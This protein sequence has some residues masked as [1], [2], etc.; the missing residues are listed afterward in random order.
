[1]STRYVKIGLSGGDKVNMKT[2]IR[3]SVMED[4]SPIIDTRLDNQD[5]KIENIVSGSPKGVYA[6]LSALQTAYPSGASGVYLTSDNGHWYY[7]N[8]SAWTDGGVYQSAGGYEEIQKDLSINNQLLQHGSIDI[9]SSLEIITGQVILTSGVVYNSNFVRTNFKQFE[10]GTVLVIEHPDDVRIGEFSS[11][12]WNSIVKF[13]HGTSVKIVTNANSYYSFSCVTESKENLKITQFSKYLNNLDDR[14]LSNTDILTNN[15][16]EINSINYVYGA[17]LGD[18]SINPEANWF[19]NTGFIKF[20]T[21]QMVK[22]IPSD[23]YE[24]RFA[25]YSSNDTSTVEYVNTLIGNNEYIFEADPAK[26]YAISFNLKNNTSQIDLNAYFCRIGKTT[27][28]VTRD[29]FSLTLKGKT[30]YGF[31]DSLMYGHYENVGMLDKLATAEKMEFIKYAVNG[32]AVCG[33]TGGYNLYNQINS[34]SSVVPDFVVFDGSTNDAYTSTA[35]GNI[36]ESYED[37]FDINTY[38]GAFEH[39]CYLLRNKY[40]TSKI[41]YV[42][43]HN[44]PTRD[45]EV[46]K[47]MHTLTK[48]ICEKWSFGYVDIFAEGQ[49]NTRIDSMRNAYSYDTLDSMT[50]GNG[51]HLTGDAYYKWYAPI[52]K[53]KLLENKPEI[54]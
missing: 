12:E 15:F 24:V 21:K 30:I 47:S 10:E 22:I 51:T 5:T 23:N 37:T 26:Y 11:T 28:F 33:S 29:E 14:V 13:E 34:A 39:A 43:P 53:M 49:I 7:W 52:I 31:G 42:F 9:T 6:S 45:L 46:L 48:Q 41:I 19:A 17:I 27:N 54:A 25:R 2:E 20:E 32:M 4:L 50:G 36:S 35:L 16:A 18:G 44:M 1:M 8:G 3:D 40:S 38:A